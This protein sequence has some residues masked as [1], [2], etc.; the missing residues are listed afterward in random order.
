MTND[1]LISIFMCQISHIHLLVG[2]SFH[3]VVQCQSGVSKF[4]A[5]F[6]PIY[7]VKLNGTKQKTYNIKRKKKL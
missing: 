3:P 2:L 4:V 5:V 1:F 7:I 6:L